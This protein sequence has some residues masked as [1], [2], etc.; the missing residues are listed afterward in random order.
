MTGSIPKNEIITLCSN[1]EQWSLFAKGLINEFTTEA[2]IKRS[3]TST[4]K[5][6]IDFTFV[7]SPEL[8]ISKSMAVLDYFSGISKNN[9]EGI[10]RANEFFVN[11]VG[12]KMWVI[13]GYIQGQT[14]IPIIL[15]YYEIID[16]CIY[17]IKFSDEDISDFF[18]AGFPTDARL[19]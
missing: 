8:C 4:V 12:K 10:R 15:L 14:R 6:K 13:G 3:E 16:I 9:A 5:I 7:Y 19:N 18:P 1:K 11:Y 17:S 2:L